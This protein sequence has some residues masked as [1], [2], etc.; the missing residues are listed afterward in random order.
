VAERG[1]N[2]AL[3]LQARSEKGRVDHVPFFMARCLIS[4]L[5]QRGRRRKRFL[6]EWVR[7]S[8]C[9]ARQAALTSLN[10]SG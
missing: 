5:P 10:R 8:E 9:R 6:L 2:I 4:D 3:I 7:S 1:V